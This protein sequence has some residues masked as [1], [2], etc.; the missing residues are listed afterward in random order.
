MPFR[1]TIFTI[2]VGFELIVSAQSFNISLCDF[3][4]NQGSFSKVVAVWHLSRKQCCHFSKEALLLGARMQNGFNFTAIES[5]ST[6]SK[7]IGNSSL[8]KGL[9]I[10]LEFQNKFNMNSKVLNYL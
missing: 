5:S 9:S 8:L 1:K 10:L 4:F 3:S 2:L 6:P 7:I